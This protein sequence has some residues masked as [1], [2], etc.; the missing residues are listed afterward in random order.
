M[1]WSL[2]KRPP[3]I[4]VVEVA[5]LAAQ[6]GFSELISTG[7]GPAGDLV[8]V[9]ASTE[10]PTLPSRRPDP[11][12]SE[13]ADGLPLRLDGR[14]VLLATYDNTGALTHSTVVD[15]EMQLSIPLVQPMGGNGYLVVG[16]SCEWR[17]DGVEQ[18]ARVVDADGRTVRQGCLGDGVQHLQRAAD[19]TLW[20]GYSDEGVFGN[21][22]WND[23]GPQP[24]GAAGLVQWSEEFVPLW[25]HD[26]E[27]SIY[28]CYTLNVSSQA[29]VLT[30]SYDEFAVTVIDKGNERSYATHKVEG[31][32][33]LL[34]D[35]DRV[36]LIGDYNS[37][38]LVIQGRLTEG[39]FVETGRAQLAI[40]GQ[41]LPPEVEF[42]CRG[43]V[44]DLIVGQ[45]WHRLD[46][47]HMEQSGDA[48]GRK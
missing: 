18:N 5:T 15:Q 7:V 14:A 16:G 30:C 2:R 9:W 33:G 17:P 44:L 43:P 13:E 11:V 40:S 25:E 24:L 45:Q 26:Q 42:H 23:P 46:L 35:G 48:G 32:R 19:G 38:G 21:Y 47:R 37:P 6:D 22:G 31:P 8:C 3:L 28:D 29:G 41:P 4:D 1:K 10:K 36:V 34:V 20:V 39:R 12:D 27:P